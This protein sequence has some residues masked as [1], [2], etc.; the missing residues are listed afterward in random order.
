M[1][2]SF[3]YNFIFMYIYIYIY[4][5]VLEPLQISLT[6]T[7]RFHTKPEGGE[8]YHIQDQRWN[9]PEEEEE[10]K[11]RGS[12]SR[13]EDF[14]LLFLWADGDSVM[15]PQCTIYA[16]KALLGHSKLGLGI[17]LEKHLSNG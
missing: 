5:I 17:E 3:Y 16:F 12:R 4:N 13:R 14:M 10:K 15:E 6:G 7:S 8:C 11:R 1:L 2:K 9:I